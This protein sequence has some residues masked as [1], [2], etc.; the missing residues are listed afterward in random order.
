VSDNLTFTS[1]VKKGVFYN[2]TYAGSFNI[3]DD[4]CGKKPTVLCYIGNKY[5]IV[6]TSGELIPKCTG[7]GFY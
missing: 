6:N 5:N 3:I 1:A 2:A 7:T 4:D